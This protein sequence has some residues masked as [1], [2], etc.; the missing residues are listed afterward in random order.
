MPSYRE[1][2]VV[3]IA[4]DPPAMLWSGVGNLLLPADEVIPSPEIALGGSELID[5]PDF[6][7]LAAG[8]TERL[9]VIVSGVDEET[10]RLALDDAPSVRNA[11][12]N[13]GIAKFD[14][15]W[16]LIEVEWESTYEA[17]S[18]NISRPVATDGKPVRTISLVIVAGDSSRSR[19]PAAYFTDPDQ[20]RRPGSED[21]TI[22]L[23]VGR[24]S[25]GTSRRFGPAD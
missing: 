1:S 20:R 24:I 3:R 23:N 21:D 2:I 14:N 8:T 4:C 11:V 22:F 16:Q 5:F 15:D 10:V 18:L 9:E 25:S 13:Q 6:Q 17:R 12:V 7:Q 19:A